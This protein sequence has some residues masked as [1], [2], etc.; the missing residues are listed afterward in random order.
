MCGCTETAILCVVDMVS[1]LT[2]KWC[3]RGCKRRQWHC[4]LMDRSFPGCCCGMLNIS[5]YIQ[6]TLWFTHLCGGVLLLQ[7]QMFPRLDGATDEAPPR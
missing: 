5:V 6:Y 1:H 4:A 3:P 7:C 2:R